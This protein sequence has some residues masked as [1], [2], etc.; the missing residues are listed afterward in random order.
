MAGFKFL[1]PRILH[2]ELGFALLL[3]APGRRN[4]AVDPQFDIAVR[5]L[6]RPVEIRLK[7]ED[8]ADPMNP[9]QGPAASPRLASQLVRDWGGERAEVRPKSVFA[10]DGKDWGCD[11]IAMAA[12]NL[13]DPDDNLDY[14]WSVC[15]V[16]GEPAY[17]VRLIMLFDAALG[18]GE[19]RATLDDVLDGG[20]F[21]EDPR[22]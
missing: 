22:M 18:P 6:D 7:V 5:L 14:E 20:M 15:L 9:S 3:P 16:K 13:K 8:L 21:W 4:P 12:Y 19:C 1:P 2:P 11:G 10:D 17:A